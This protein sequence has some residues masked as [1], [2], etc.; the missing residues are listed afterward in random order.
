MQSAGL[1]LKLTIIQTI[2]TK[3]YDNRNIE[4]PKP[5]LNY[6]DRFDRKREFFGIFN[7]IRDS[8][9]G[10]SS[11]TTMSYVQLKICFL[12]S[13]KMF[14]MFDLDIHCGYF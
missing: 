2:R 6:H 13:N 3:S 1:C 7:I 4:N 5:F 10:N 8:S 11:W 14:K 9:S 12:N